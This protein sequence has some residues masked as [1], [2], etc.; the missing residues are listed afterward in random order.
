M[1]D[2]KLYIFDADG[3]LRRC[4]VEGQPCPNKPGEWELMP[5]V[6]EK[7]A[8]IKWGTPYDRGYAAR[9]IASNQGGVGYGYL[10]FETA[11]Q[12]LKQT[13]VEAFGSLPAT[14]SIQICPHRKDEDCECR[15]PKPLMILRL[16]NAWQLRPDQVLYVGDMDTDRQA[17]ENAGVDF[18]W[19]KDFF[20]W[21]ADE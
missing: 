3:T 6:K 15:K 8:T 21:E 12:M 9:G 7:L 19:A 18:M 10:N 16:M 13:F 5:G 20:G 17:A 4:T 11:Y 2:Y 1:G 14:G